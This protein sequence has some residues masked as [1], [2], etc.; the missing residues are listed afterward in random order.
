MAI[1][2]RMPRFVLRHGM[3]GAVC[4]LLALFAPSA[5]ASRKVGMRP[6]CWYASNVRRPN[7]KCS[8]N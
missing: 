8:C 6:H 7:G 3:Q 5:I 4:H 1:A 2:S